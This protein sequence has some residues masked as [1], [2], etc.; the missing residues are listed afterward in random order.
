MYKLHQ[1]NQNMHKTVA[2]K[3]TLVPEQAQETWSKAGWEEE[4]GLQEQMSRLH[5][6]P[7]EGGATCK[8]ELDGL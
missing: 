4:A 8:Y 7:S 3:F 5:K 2:I 1:I 6:A